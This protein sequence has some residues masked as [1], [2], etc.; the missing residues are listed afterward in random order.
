MPHTGQQGLQAAKDPGTQFTQQKNRRGW[1]VVA[2]PRGPRPE[3]GLC[4]PFPRKPMCESCRAKSR[5]LY[6]LVL[7]PPET[8][9]F[10]FLGVLGPA[11][12]PTLN[13]QTLPSSRRGAQE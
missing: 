3:A 8:C 12:A 6:C 2:Q 4:P 7:A 1:A 9:A 5:V 13:A 11:P 10:V